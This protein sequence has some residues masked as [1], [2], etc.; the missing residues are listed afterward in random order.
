MPTL[1]LHGSV[2]RIF[3]CQRRARDR[4]SDPDAE[5]LVFEGWATACRANRGRFSR[6]IGDLIKR[7]EHGAPVADWR[8]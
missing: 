5:L 7:A 1:V 8:S 4:R 2:D 6:R 3:R